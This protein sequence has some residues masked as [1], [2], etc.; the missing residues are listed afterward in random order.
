MRIPPPHW[1]LCNLD[2]LQSQVRLGYKPS[3]KQESH[4]QA[5]RAV[6]V[7]PADERGAPWKPLAGGGAQAGLSR[8]PPKVDAEFVARMEAVLALY[9][10]TPDERRPVVC[11]DETPAPADWRS[12]RAGARRARHAA[13]L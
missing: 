6:R 2:R 13:P 5:A 4:Q 8:M 9:A 7:E 11:F 1:P 3:R 10:E 12:A